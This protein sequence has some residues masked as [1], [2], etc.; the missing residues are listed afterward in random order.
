VAD[1]AAIRSGL[2]TRLET[3]TDWQVSAHILSSPT[4][5]CAMIYEGETE[6]DATIGDSDGDHNLVVRVIAPFAS[7][8]QAQRILD[9]FRSA[10]GPRSVKQAIEGDSTLGGICDDV[11]V[12]GVSPDTVY[13]GLQGQPIGIGCEFRVLVVGTGDE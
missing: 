12:V 9:E 7:D 6:Y 1:V 8:V 13:G 2:K 3:L 4:A 11:R 10:T 5:P